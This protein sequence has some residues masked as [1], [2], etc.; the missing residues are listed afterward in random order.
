MDAGTDTVYQY[1]NAA[2]RTSGSPNPST[3]FALAAGNT[4]PQGIADP[5]VAGG[6]L[7]SAAGSVL[8][9][10]PVSAAGPASAVAS[11]SLTLR[12][13]PDDNAAGWGWLGVP[14]AAADPEFSLWGNQGEQSRIDL[15]TSL[16][17]G[18]ALGQDHD[19]DGAAEMLAAE[20][21]GMPTSDKSAAGTAVLDLIFAEQSFE[22]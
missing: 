14:T 4:N 19:D 3:S 8:P 22:I 2:T 15:W 5:P 17:K 20:T 16:F 12:A 9:A 1:D 11:L 13:L 6:S 7:V 21:W 18:Q 10:Q